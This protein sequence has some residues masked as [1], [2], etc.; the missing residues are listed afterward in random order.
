M[1]AMY[2]SIRHCVI[3][4][5]PLGGISLDNGQAVYLDSPE[6]SK[7]LPENVLLGV[8]SQVVDEDAPAA[9]VHGG[10]RRGRG[11]GL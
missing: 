1:F 9:A 4:F 8:G 10:R 3:P 11:S 2:K 7:E 5:I 6:G